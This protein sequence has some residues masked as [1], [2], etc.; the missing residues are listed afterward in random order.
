ME[1]KTKTISIENCDAENSTVD[2]TA[3]LNSVFNEFELENDECSKGQDGC[4]SLAS[5]QKRWDTGV[6]V[7]AKT[8]CTGGNADIT[9]TEKKTCAQILEEKQNDDLITGEGNPQ[10]LMYIIFIF[11]KI[12]E[13]YF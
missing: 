6:Y 2:V 5:E 7:F 3:E 1:V 10:C 13:L 12:S 4:I 9:Y 8:S 11:Y